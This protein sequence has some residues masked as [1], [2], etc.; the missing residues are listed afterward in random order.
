MAQPRF[1]F[2]VGAAGAG[3]RWIPAGAG[4]P[5]EPEADPG[6]LVDWVGWRLTSGNNHELGRSA[7]LYPDLAACR[8]AVRRLQWGIDQV[9]TLISADSRTARWRWRVD[10]AGRP[11]AV[12]GRVYHRQRECQ[13]NVRQFLPAVRVAGIAPNGIILS[14]GSH[15]DAAPDGPPDPAGGPSNRARSVT[16]PAGRARSAG[17]A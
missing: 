7:A 1:L 8:E 17:P 14:R 9:G 5:T 13:Y 10:R 11:V 3:R 2:V 15:G 12:C 16:R 4:L 6:A